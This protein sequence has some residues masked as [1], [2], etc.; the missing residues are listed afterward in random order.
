MA[1]KTGHYCRI[2][3]TY[4][5]NEKFSGKGRKIHI[6]K[7]CMKMPA[8]ERALIESKDEIFDYLKQSNISSKNIARLKTLSKS[9]NA[10]IRELARIVFQV[11]EIAPRKKNR[12]KIIA[13]KK[14][15]LIYKLEDT[16]L[17][18]AHKL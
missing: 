9:E 18:L 8:N 14:K 7:K 16:G 5:A 12:L 4:R 10:E 11:A 1:K 13:G 6:C 2:C 3:N 17:I 15:S